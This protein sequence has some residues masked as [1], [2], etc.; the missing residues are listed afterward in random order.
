MMAAPSLTTRASS[1]RQLL[2]NLQLRVAE[3]LAYDRAR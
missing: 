3:D 1:C 2:E